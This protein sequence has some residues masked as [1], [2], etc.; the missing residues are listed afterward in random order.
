MFSSVETVGV[1]LNNIYRSLGVPRQRESVYVTSTL[2][3]FLRLSDLSRP[4]SD[5][6]VVG[7]YVI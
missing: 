7:L 1:A 4:I 6:V 2:N 5:V 3:T